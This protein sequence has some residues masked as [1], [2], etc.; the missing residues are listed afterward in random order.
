MHQVPDRAWT[1]P[2]V[3]HSSPAAD[4]RLA[5]RAGGVGE[6]E[7][8]SEVVLVVMEV[9]LVVVAHADVD[10]QIRAHSDVVFK[11]Y[12]ENLFQK[13]YVPVAR[14]Q[15]IRCG[16]SAGV[17]SGTGEGIGS[18]AVGKVIEPAAADVG[19]V[20]AKAE[21][22]SAAGVGGEISSVE[23]IFGAARVGLRPARS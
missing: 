1:C 13:C 10:G 16:D 6:A 19:D 21:L 11:E 23:V 14:L 20:D 7:A 2:V 4:D 15:Q 9:V 8:R 18:G 3:E 5:F 12:A 22:M 17:I